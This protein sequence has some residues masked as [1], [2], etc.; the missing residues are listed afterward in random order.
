[1]AYVFRCAFELKYRYVLEFASVSLMA[2]LREEP[3]A[4][5]P[6]IPRSGS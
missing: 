4:L 2:R 5:P 3:A 1:M 6:P